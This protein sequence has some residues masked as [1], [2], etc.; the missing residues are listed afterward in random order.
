MT[1]YC[2]YLT[3]YSGSKLP[4]FYIGSSSISRIESGYRGTVSSK[5]Y[6]DVWKKELKE[7]PH[8]FKTRVLTTHNTRKEA[9]DKELSF[10]KSLSVVSSTMYINMSY[11]T[12]NGFF[13]VSQKGL[14]KRKSMRNKLRGNKNAQGNHKNKTEEHKS[15]IKA[16][17]TGKIRTDSH[18]LAIS[19]SKKGGHWWNDGN[20][21]TKMSKQ[22][23]GD[24]WALGIKR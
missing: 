2:T 6:K 3:V 14:P 17:L 4:P 8:L 23:P 13:G 9:T 12:V 15:K 10:Q 21:N 20:G 7:N 11:A 18:S 22:C 24:G 16:A 19:N 5:I 1:I